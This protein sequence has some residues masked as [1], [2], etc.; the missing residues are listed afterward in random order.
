MLEKYTPS[1][2]MSDRLTVAIFFQFQA[3]H[4]EEF[5]LWKKH[6]S[7]ITKKSISAEMGILNKSANENLEGS[8]EGSGS[9]DQGLS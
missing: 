2:V 4:K 6:I 9:M 8:C 1:Q 5:E 3:D 7:E